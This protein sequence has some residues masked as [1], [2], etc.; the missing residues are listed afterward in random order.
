M[1]Y[2]NLLKSDYFKSIIKDFFEIEPFKNLYTISKLVTNNGLNINKYF[3][4]FLSK[5][6]QRDCKNMMKLFK[7]EAEDIN[8]SHEI[9]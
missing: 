4:Q 7:V 5:I 2:P 8:S 6:F 9:F 1:T 3:T